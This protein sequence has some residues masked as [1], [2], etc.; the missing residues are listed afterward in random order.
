[1]A[2][3]KTVHLKQANVSHPCSSRQ[4]LENW[5]LPSQEVATSITLG[6]AQCVRSAIMPPF[7]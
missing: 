3:L 4:L 6:L 5:S 1:M 7:Y 2:F